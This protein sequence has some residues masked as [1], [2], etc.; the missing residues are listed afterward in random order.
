[1]QG[2]QSGPFN[3]KLSHT[4][5]NRGQVSLAPPRNTTTVSG[6]RPVLRY[7]AA[8]R[9]SSAWKSR[10]PDPTTLNPTPKTPNPTTTF[11]VLGSFREFACCWSAPT[12]SEQQP[13]QKKTQH[14]KPK[15]ANPFKDPLG[16]EELWESPPFGVRPGCT[17]TKWRNAS[18]S[19]GPGLSGRIGSRK[20]E[21]RFK[22]G[23]VFI[24]F[25]P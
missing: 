1:M 11:G 5:R 16:P 12:W 24:G 19:R 23:L 7:H 8:C 4:A 9:A 6:G 14:P 15:A 21:T 18:R 25:G 2:V 17:V 20:L 13:P 10:Q 3:P 22:R